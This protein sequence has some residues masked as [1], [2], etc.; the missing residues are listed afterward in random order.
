M[1]FNS[2]SLTDT[3]TSPL[4]AQHGAAKRGRS[5]AETGMAKLHDP[6]LRRFWFSTPGSLGIGVTAYSRSEAE[7]LARDAAAR[8]G[9]DFEPSSVTEDVDIR[10]LDQ[11]HVVPNMGPP[12]FRGGWF[13]RFN[14]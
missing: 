8:L 11:K 7:S 4:C 1:R 10:D 2:A 12:N 6:K 13:P 3:F 5:T 9:H 14:I